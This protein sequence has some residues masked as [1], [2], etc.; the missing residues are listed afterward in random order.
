MVGSGYCLGVHIGHDRGAALVKDGALVACVAEE[1]LD[2]RKHSSSPELPL[3]SIRAVLSCAELTPR[4]LA[5]AAISYTNVRID[6][7]IDQLADELRDVLGSSKLRVFGA[8]H[9]DCHALSAYYTSGA[10]RAA[11]MVADGSGD[12]VG[13]MIESES[14]Y[15]GNG[16]SITLVERRLQS[17][18]MTRTDRRNA[19]NPRY[20]HEDDR[21]KQIS[22]GRKYEQLTY[23]IGFGHGQSGKTMGLAAFS[24]P[25]FRMGM[26]DENVFQFSLRFADGLDQIYELWDS[27]GKP[28]HQYILENAAAIAAAAQV[29]LHDFMVATLRGVH[30]RSRCDTLCAAG[31]VFL[32]CRMNH[33]VLKKTPFKRLHV[34]PAAGDDGQAV[35]AAFYAHNEIFGGAAPKFL[36]NVFLGP[37]HSDEEIEGRI[38]H[39]GLYS[40]RFNS[41]WL[42]DR[43]VEDLTQGR[44]VGLLRGRS[45]IGP[46]ALGHRSILADPRCPGLKDGLNRLKGRE[47]FRPFAP[48]VTAECQFKY[49]E[50]KQESPFMLFATHL[51][52]EYRDE[53]SAIVHAD[54]TSRVQA[55]EEDEDP[56]LHALLKAFEIRT[57]HPI[58]LNTSF[59]LA[60]D[61][62]VQSPHD[63]IT[64]FLAS[65]LDVLVLEEFYIDQKSCRRFTERR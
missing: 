19:F 60:G 51:K 55:V 33:E 26:P 29:L 8:G 2:R 64:T 61:P 21:K 30:E 62:I 44:I 47:L 38:N 3:R 56:F 52:Q 23:L 35:G 15:E 63:A 49:F 46:R 40:K 5:G 65:S 27:S 24:D 45:E 7:I 54:G 50:L 59:N 39:F 58:L 11:V 12:I 37:R 17:F 4:D 25:L 16:P 14:F 22:L 34:F 18:G 32:N 6:N 9:H 20:L 13:S 31:G 57:G 48:I 43:L 53:L 41:E 10:D 36:R 28:W 42:I 1:R